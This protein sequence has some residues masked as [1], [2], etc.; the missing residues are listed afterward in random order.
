MRDYLRINVAART[1]SVRDRLGI[2][3]DR[4]GRINIAFF[5]FHQ[6]PNSFLSRILITDGADLADVVLRSFIQHHHDVQGTAGRAL[7]THVTDRHIDEG[8][9]LVILAHALQVLLQLRFIKSA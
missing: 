4:L 7:L 8:V 1:I 3:A 9:V 2:V 5:Y 6:R